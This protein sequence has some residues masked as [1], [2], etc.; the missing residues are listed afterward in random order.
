[1]VHYS[2]DPE[3]PTKSCKPRGSNPRV[4]FKNTPETAWAIKGM[5]I[6]TVVT[7]LKAVTLQKQCVP[8]CHYNGSPFS[9]GQGLTPPV[10]K[11]PLLTVGQSGWAEMT[12]SD[13]STNVGFI[14]TKC[15]KETFD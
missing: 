2:F 7:S 9:R 1:M 14:S 3:K 11:A 4:H 10:L 12:N 15:E 5:C 13:S 6:Q 8:L